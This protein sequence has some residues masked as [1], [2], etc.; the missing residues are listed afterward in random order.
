MEWKGLVSF[1]ELQF[2]S[3]LNKLKTF[4]KDGLEMLFY[5]KFRIF[6]LFFDKLSLHSV[7]AHFC[8]CKRVC[9]KKTT[10]RHCE[11][12]SRIYPQIFDYYNTFED[13]IIDNLDFPEDFSKFFRE[14]LLISLDVCYDHSYFINLQKAKIYKCMYFKFIRNPRKRFQKMLSVLVR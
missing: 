11:L 10:E 9:D 2:Y 13:I 8:Y 1:M 14:T 12:C 3:F 5:L 7:F 4:L 6:S